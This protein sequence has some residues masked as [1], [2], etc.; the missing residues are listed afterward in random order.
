MP[1]TSQDVSKI[2]TAK[3]AF[4]FD[5]FKARA[6]GGKY[7]KEKDFLKYAELAFKKLKSQ[8]LTKSGNLVAV[9]V[10]ASTKD[11][12]AA[13]SVLMLAADHF[14]TAMTAVGDKDKNA[15]LAIKN[16]YNAVLIERKEAISGELANRKD[17]SGEFGKLEKS[18][19]YLHQIIKSQRDSL[20]RI[21]TDFEKIVNDKDPHRRSDGID[22]WKQSSDFRVWQAVPGNDRKWKSNLDDL[23]KTFMEITT[24][25]NGPADKMQSS[26]A[27]TLED[28]EDLRDEC[29][30]DSNHIRNLFSK[31][32]GRNFSTFDE[33]ALIPQAKR[34]AK[35][36]GAISTLAS[37]LQKDLEQL[38]KDDIAVALKADALQDHE[39]TWSVL[40]PKIVPL[41]KLLGEVRDA[42]E[43]NEALLPKVKSHY[44]KGKR[45]YD[46][47]I[48]MQSAIEKLIK[49]LA[50]VKAP[51][52]KQPDIKKLVPQYNKGLDSLIQLAKSQANIASKFLKE[53][54]PKQSNQKSLQEVWRKHKDSNI[55]LK[56]WDPKVASSTF[57]K[58]KQAIFQL[59]S[60]YVS[61]QEKSGE[62]AKPKELQQL[63]DRLEGVAVAEL[64]DAE[65]EFVKQANLITSYDGPFA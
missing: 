44:E 57:S 64:I 25:T 6:A 59:N 48:K 9:D 32:I 46:E 26:I 55:D 33:K 22:E 43:P 47:V 19:K 8:G 20:A 61:W 1:F 35:D 62:K 21:K 37:K 60:D 15:K 38:K 13:E 12:N 27:D 39:K 51:K 56:S 7:K 49:E 18:A 31:A 4:T 3:D 41:E 10:E 52:L 42:Y 30:E 40:S 28:V 50:S 17:S 14:S 29:L 58:L 54:A 11:L 5:W 2:K 23:N 65:E 24:K 63:V 53:Q 16:G 34:L 36:A 45:A